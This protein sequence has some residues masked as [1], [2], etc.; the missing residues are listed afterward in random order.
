MKT[1]IKRA[2]SLILA[3]L[4]AVPML[5]TSVSLQGYALESRTENFDLSQYIPTGDP[6]TDICNIALLQ[7][8]R[9]GSQFGYTEA[10]CA[11][12]VSDCA[13]LAGQSTA[14][15]A[16]SWVPS[17]YQGVLDQGGQIVTNP[18]PGDL[19]IMDFG[20][21]GRDDQHVELVY[22]VNGDYVLTVGGNTGGTGNP[23][24]N[25][26]RVQ[27]QNVW[28][29]Y[30]T[31]LFAYFVRPNY[32]GGS[33]TTKP[34][35]K[36]DSIGTVPY[37]QPHTVA[38]RVWSSKALTR[39]TGK[40]IRLPDNTTL[41]EHTANLDGDTPVYSYILENSEIDNNLP[42]GSLS[43]GG[44]YMLEVTAV[45][46]NVKIGK[47]TVEFTVSSNPQASA[48]K[49]ELKS[50]GEIPF[51][52]PHS[53]E[54]TITSSSAITMV[55]G[56][57]LS[58]TTVMQS[59]SVY[60]NS[61]TYTLKD[62][63]LDNSLKFGK[64]EPGSYTLEIT[65]ANA[66]KKTATKSVSFT[67]VKASTL[68]VEL[69]CPRY[70]ELGMMEGQLH[71]TA[72]SNYNIKKVT[73]VF[74]KYNEKLSKYEE[75]STKTTTATYDYT[76]YNLEDSVQGTFLQNQINGQGLGKYK[77]KL[78]VWDASGASVTK[79]VTFEIVKPS[80]LTVKLVNPGNVEQG[81]MTEKFQGTAS[82]NYNIKKV[83][84]VLYKYNEKLGKY[85]QITT[86]TTTATY[87]Y[88]TYYLEKSVQGTFLRDTINQQGTGRYK[89]KVTVTDSIGKT[90]SDAVV[91][92]VV[93]PS[94]LSLTLVDPGFIEC[95]GM[96]EKFQG[97][98]T[99][100]YNIKTVI[101]ELLNAKQERIGG[102]TTT[103]TYDYTTYYLE[104]S[105]QGT[106]L[107]D[108]INQQA[109]GKYTVRVTVVDAIGKIAT[110]SMPI[111][112]AEV[113]TL[114]VTLTNPGTLVCGQM[115]GSF[116]GVVESDH[117]LQSIT[118]MLCTAAGQEIAG[119]TTKPS[120]YMKIYL[121]KSVL[122]TFLKNAINE[123]APGTYKVIVTAVNNQGKTV[124]KIVTFKIISA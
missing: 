56:R 55:T 75:I 83:V 44:S 87:D 49:I 73:S 51:G 27:T 38:G 77:V 11:D 69:T 66:E 80:T 37:G 30:N 79:T 82:S 31:S 85:E 24:T 72:T 57:I 106:Y 33:G 95:G 45:D 52:E 53:I 108:L 89:V 23:A 96:T 97:T 3:I 5:L 15:P 4:L 74:Y 39:V 1:Q 110:K 65:A 60:P 48:P 19:A 26:V 109:P 8:G 93:T 123:Q 120:S 35:V 119:K 99:S 70:I 105:I 98:A 113:S 76:T 115:A 43:A 103:A 104:K 40:I 18:Q 84:S 16:N 88:T 50:I 116:E 100:N 9:T 34:Q 7:S 22:Q 20:Y 121:H 114:S 12:F 61:L 13:K 2:V 54:G 46:V 94:T 58:G 122:G 63:A 78:T 117:Y 107:R 67:V 41:Y 47:D 86:K 92:K 124:T 59:V 112:V 71:G 64:L 36:L 68:S 81:Q 21:C 90:A 102:K 28:T 25:K 62:S 91:F 118:V 42:F 17:L 111:T 29:Y 101:T 6:V 10:W 14:V 32:G